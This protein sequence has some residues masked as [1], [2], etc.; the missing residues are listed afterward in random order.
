MTRIRRLSI[1]PGTAIALIALFFALG[2]SAFAVGERIQAPSVAQQRCANGSVRGIAVV[3]GIA[4]QG[5]ANFPDSFTAAGN[6]F[7][8]KF[9]CTGKAV[10]ARRVE[11]AS[12]RSGSRGS[13]GRARSSAR[14][15]RARRRSQSWRRTRLQHRDAPGWPRR[16]GRPPVH[17]GRSSESYGRRGETN[18]PIAVARRSSAAAIA[19]N[20][21][22]ISL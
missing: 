13:P 17:D 8:R 18:A 4:S 14:R 1:T 2:G 20:S 9:N 21:H 5:I 7:G 6:L 19:M 15:R 22:V 12:S 3:T 10:Q 11:T 16:R